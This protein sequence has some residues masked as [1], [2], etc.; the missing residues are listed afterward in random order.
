PGR[1]CPPTGRIAWAAPRSRAAA[2]VFRQALAQAAARHL[3]AWAGKLTPHVLRHFCASQL[4]LAG[5]SL[6]AIP[7]LLGHSWTGTTARYIHV[8]T[9]HAEDAWAAGRARAAGRWKGLVR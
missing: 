8:H 1:L 9:T 2:D 4:Y 7:E 6:F 5:V 3:P